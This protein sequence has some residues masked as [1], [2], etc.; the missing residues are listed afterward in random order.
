MQR[1]LPDHQSDVAAAHVQAG[2]HPV[3]SLRAQRVDDS[4]V[5]VLRAEVVVL[6]SRFR[7]HLAGNSGYPGQ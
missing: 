5:R 6:R 4:L 1:R 7:A 3:P 2:E